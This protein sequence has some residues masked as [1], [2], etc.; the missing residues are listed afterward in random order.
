MDQLLSQAPVRGQRV[1]VRADLNVP[2]KNGVVGDDT[3][4]RATLPTLRRLAS[5]GAR[6]IVASHL[7]RPKG[8]ADPQ[9][10]LAPV[11]K[12]LSELLGMPVVFVPDCVGAAAESAVEKLPSGGVALLENL[13]FH[14]EEEKNDPTFARRLAALADVYVNDAFGTAHRAHASTAGMVGLVPRVAAGDLLQAELQHLRVVLEPIRPLVCVLGGAKVSDKI[15]VLEALAERADVLAIGGAMAYTFLRA[16]GEPTG[17]SRVEEDHVSD[18]RRVLQAA[19]GAGRRIL[20]PV[21]H[22][23]AEKLSAD[24][25]SRVAKQIPDGWLGVDIG[26]ETAA[27]YAA[28]VRKAGTVFW[29]GPMGVFEIESFAKGTEA[30]AR[31]IADSKAVSV[32]GG[33]DSLAAVNK[34][35]LGSRVTHLSTGGGASLEFVQGLTLPGVAALER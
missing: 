9:Y 5:A 19:A 7:G 27:I 13:R 26:P 3:R 4:I 14:A 11:A 12:R 32:V 28:E 35:G 34:L 18:A 15:A 31:A 8:K 6:V 2:T 23:V 17:S 20:L 21:D 16:E 10:S 25:P 24:T 30:V 22:V 29:N 33:G 1:F